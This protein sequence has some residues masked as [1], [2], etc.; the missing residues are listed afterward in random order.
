MKENSRK[1]GGNQHLTEEL[2]RN[3]PAFKKDLIADA[4]S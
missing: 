3:L 4:K 1:A 2:V